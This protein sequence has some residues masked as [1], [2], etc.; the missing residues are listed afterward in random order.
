MK[1][2]LGCFNIKNVVHGE[3][4]IIQDHTLV[5]NLDE[6]RMLIS[7]DSRFSRV[8]LE[9]VHPG[10]SVRIINVLDVIEPRIK[11]EGGV[12][13]PGW[14][15]QV[16]IAGLGKTYKLK[17]VGVTEVGLMQDFYGAIL[18]M[19]GPGSDLTNYSNLHHVVLVTDPAEGI[20]QAEYSHAL[21][22]AGLK[23]A[24]YLASA[25]LSLDPEDWRVY[26]IPPL[27]KS[28]VKGVVTRFSTLEGAKVKV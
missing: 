9:I 22:T 24:T 25:S 5:V 27:N 20:D 7:E 26:E 17:G 18:D 8:K 16:G 23:A 6:L 12:V 13:F 3:R 19:S 21:K 1:L 14:L 10:E 28:G 4:T 11:V 2:E 15:G